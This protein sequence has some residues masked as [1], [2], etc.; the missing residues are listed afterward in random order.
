MNK[1]KN[2]EPKSR[3]T[4][5]SYLLCALF[6]ALTAIFSQIMIPLP[7][8]PVPINLALLA[9]WLCGI[10]LGAKR[11][12]ISILVYILLGAI[13]V[14][15]FHGFM[16]GI[17]VLAGPTGGYIVGYLPAV[18]I[19]GFLYNRYISVN[20]YNSNNHDSN[21]NISYTDNYNSNGNKHNKQN[22]Q[23]PV[24]RILKTIAIGLPALAAC[25][26]T[27]T[28]WFVITAGT[29]VLAALMMCVIPF[30]PGD[31]L[32][33]VLAAAVMETLRKRGIIRQ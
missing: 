14:P 12:A 23:K 6:A 21:K 15:V 17:G 16:G 4:L 31:I 19:F 26:F 2:R 33:F 10:V 9:V 32:K 29:N 7:F 18:V 25:Y 24:I 5:Y 11:G 1:D 20:N 8:T 27:G 13:G 28:V 22:H 30:V 3:N